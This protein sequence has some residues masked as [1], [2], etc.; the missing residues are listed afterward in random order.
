MKTKIQDLSGAQLDW[1]AAKCENFS[2]LD[3]RVMP[4]VIE[5]IKE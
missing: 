2:G 4:Y 5:I 3:S 1:A